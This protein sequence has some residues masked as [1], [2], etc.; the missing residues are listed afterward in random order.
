[1]I[2]A[3]CREHLRNVSEWGGI[4]WRNEF[5][6]LQVKIP[7]STFSFALMLSEFFK[8]VHN[9]LKDMSRHAKG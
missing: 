9:S 8:C 6:N 1:M 5:G 2:T 4:E 7:E 3:P